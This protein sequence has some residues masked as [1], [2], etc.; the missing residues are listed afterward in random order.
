M[1][2]AVSVMYGARTRTLIVA[3]T[4]AGGIQS[5]TYRAPSPEM[6]KCVSAIVHRL[7]LEAGV[8]NVA[9]ET[10]AAIFRIHE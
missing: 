4:T 6:V 9:D 8:R 7:P 5:Q 10:A 3:P 1:A 2:N